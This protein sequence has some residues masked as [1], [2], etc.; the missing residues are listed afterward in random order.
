MCGLILK[1]LFQVSNI[2]FKIC[3]MIH[4]LEIKFTRTKELGESLQTPVRD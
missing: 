2:F 4:L 1:F 3:C